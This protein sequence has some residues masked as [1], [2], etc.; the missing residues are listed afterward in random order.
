MTITPE[1]ETVKG[2]VVVTCG[3]HEFYEPLNSPVTIKVDGK[4]S[5]IVGGGSSREPLERAMLRAGGGEYGSIIHFSYGLHPAARVTGKSFIEDS[6][7]MGANAV[8]LGIPWWL[9]GGGENHP[10][11]AMMEQSIWIDGEQI[12]RDGVVI[13]PGALRERV[14][15]LVP[16]LPAS[17][18]LRHENA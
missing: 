3:F 12:V 7:S 16:R 4:I 1:I 10:D 18:T 5:E 11:T 15:K 6:R 13:G 14:K 17:K 2:T 8:G 9:P